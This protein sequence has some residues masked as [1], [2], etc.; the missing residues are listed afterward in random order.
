MTHLHNFALL[1]LLVVSFC[2]GLFCEKGLWHKEKFVGKSVFKSAA[3]VTARL[4]QGHQIVLANS[5]K[6]NSQCY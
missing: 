2:L 5:H 4:K 1:T 6:G 3:S